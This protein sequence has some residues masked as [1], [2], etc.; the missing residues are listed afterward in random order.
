MKITNTKA[1]N[2]N[3]KTNT[4][5]KNFKDIES[6]IK[7]DELVE[8]IFPDYIKSNIK[9]TTLTVE[10]ILRIYILGRYFEMTPIGLEKALLQFDDFRDFALL[11]PSID[12]IPNAES[13]SKFYA[14][15]EDRNLTEKIK[16][17]FQNKLKKFQY[18]VEF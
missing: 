2:K 16:I 12:I 9:P 17:G 6:L 13:I 11:D 4:N 15:F 1:L 8:A 3:I 14:L 18:S 5:L 7:W 10:K